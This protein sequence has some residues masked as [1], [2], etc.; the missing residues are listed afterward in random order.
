[1]QSVVRGAVFGLALGPMAVGAVAQKRPVT[2][3]LV[4]AAV[5][6]QG[7]GILPINMVVIDPSVPAGAV[8]TDRPTLLKWT[9]SLLAEGALS[10]APEVKWIPATE[11]RRIA[12]RGAG[13]VP[14]P[15]QMG[16]SVMR[17]WSIT[18]VP[19][20]LR[21]NLRKLLAVAGGWRY[22]LIPAALVLSADSTGTLAANLSVLL[23]DARTGR[24]VW[25]SMAKGS[26]GSA[27]QVLGKAIATIFPLEGIDP[28]AE[29]PPR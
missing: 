16:Q 9:D 7:V 25:R 28:S 5:A 27:D 10:R 8:A 2:Q 29:S 20:P 26:G 14:N 22:A 6:G 12:K 17:G 21:S 24:V 4:V 23:A 1:M 19:D 11:L 3:G 18:T 15:D 13:L